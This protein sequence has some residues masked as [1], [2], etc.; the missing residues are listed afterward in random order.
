VRINPKGDTVMAG[1]AEPGK[2]VIIKDADKEIGRVTS[3]RRGEWVFVPE[4]P[5]APG[6]RRLSLETPSATK[7]PSVAGTPSAAQ[8]PAAAK[9]PEP[10]KGKG[11][12]LSEH[13]VVLV[14][15]ER[16]KDI[17]GRPTKK[18]SQ[19]LALKVPREG[20]GATWVLQKPTPTGDTFVL[21]VD[22]VDYDDAG[23][24]TISGH[25]PKNALV[26][27]Y[28]NNRFIGHSRGDGTGAWS[29]SPDAPVAPGL[30][31]LRADQ[32]DAGGKV[33]ARVSLPF[34]RAAFLTEM[35]SGTF[36]V[37]QPGN[38]LWRLA[39]RTYGTGFE[40]TVIYEAN[41]E[42]IKDPDLIFPG[43]VFALPVTN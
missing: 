32:V 16:D 23:R 18:P 24:L 27:L 15:P 1:R 10:E 8:T 9:A 39:R 37:V 34:S 7:T 20:K 11:S 38:S 21:I 26:Q 3:D 6:T 14:V 25:A 5:L 33:L 13:V 4:Q 35:G 22:S 36:V 17:A 2:T 28:L 42:Q 40:Y 12:V 41:R 29:L 19:P 31:T 43:Q 30:Y